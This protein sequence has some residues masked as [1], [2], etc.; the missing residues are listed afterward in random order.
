MSA[1]RL[2]IAG[3]GGS[4]KTTIAGTLSRLLA[5]QGRVVVAVDAD[6]NPNLA[7]TLG[8]PPD[9]ARTIVSLPRTL[10]RRETHDDGTVTSRF[11]AEPLQVLREYAAAGPD[12]VQLLVMGA[13][14]H[15]GAG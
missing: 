11:T 9:R 15:G 13:V 3:K 1:I 7:A 12:R 6:T 2:A 10:M 8:I 14:G 4:G 5:R